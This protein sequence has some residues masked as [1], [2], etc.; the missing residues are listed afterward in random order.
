MHE[1]NQEGVIFRQILNTRVQYSN[2]NVQDH[3]DESIQGNTNHTQ[4][5]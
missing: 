3:I 1:K 4:R 2:M 5:A